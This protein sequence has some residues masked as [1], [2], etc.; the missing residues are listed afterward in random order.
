MTNSY[1]ISSFVHY[2]SATDLE[3]PLPLHS[4]SRGADSLVPSNFWNKTDEFNHRKGFTHVPPSLPTPAR[5]CRA[6]PGPVQ[7]RSARA[8]VIYLHLPRFNFASC[9]CSASCAPPVPELFHFLLPNYA[10]FIKFQ[11]NFLQAFS[12]PHAEVIQTP[13]FYLS[14]SVMKLEVAWEGR[15]SG[16]L[17]FFFPLENIHRNSEDLTFKKE[18][19]PARSLLLY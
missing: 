13:P 19:L 3:F 16:K 1:K 14:F 4:P 6:V 17:G 15:E 18:K 8:A 11:P 5:R 12:S 2:F 10:R 9:F 7:P